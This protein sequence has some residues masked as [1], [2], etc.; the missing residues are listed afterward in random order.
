MESECKLIEH[1][2]ASRTQQTRRENQWRPPPRAIEKHT[3][4]GSEFLVFAN[5]LT[6]LTQYLTF[7]AAMVNNFNINKYNFVYEFGTAHWPFV[8]A[9]GN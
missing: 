5:A 3:L 8:L 7:K 1:R 6:E 9:E 2:V 4:V